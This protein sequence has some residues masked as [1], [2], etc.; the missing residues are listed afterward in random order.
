MH[1]DTMSA[2][3]SIPTMAEYAAALASRG[4]RILRTSEGSFWVGYE[5]G[6]VMRSPKFHTAPPSR[7]EIR[8]LFWD[9]RAAAL[10]TYSLE[11][12]DSHPANAWLYLCTDRS[13]SLDKLAPAVRRNVR[14]GLRELRI[15][16]ITPDR[17]LV[18]GVRAFCD[19]R[20]RVGLADGTPEEFRRQF[21]LRDRYSGQV[22]LGAW[23]NDKLAAFLSI[24]EVD[25]WAE[26]G[27]FSM[28]ALLNLRPNDA[29]IFCALSQYLTERNFRT[30]SYGLSSVQ[31]DSNII[32]LHAF[33]TKLGFE[34]RPVHRAFIFH[35][36]L[37]P[38]ANRLTLWS[39]NAALRIM[40]RD[41]HLKKVGGVLAFIL[42]NKAPKLP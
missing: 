32:G 19:T 7:R 42:A 29:L 30:V 27:C 15:E 18:H 6:A 40:P 28:D 4:T 14:R 23:K 10:I 21:A 36:L 41:R 37:R 1:A 3:R 8:E 35:P 22:F 39:V 20:R 31:A 13:Y 17:L 34:A 38:F 16:P 5:T 25:D 2:N 9:S 26:T 12:D 33:K 11:P 24:I